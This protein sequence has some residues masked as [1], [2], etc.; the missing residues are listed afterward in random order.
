MICCKWV[1]VKISYFSVFG[2]K[3]FSGK[4]CRSQGPA[5]GTKI[6]VQNVFRFIL[7][8]VIRGFLTEFGILEFQSISS[9][10]NRNCVCADAI[11]QKQNIIEQLC[12]GFACLFVPGSLSLKSH[13]YILKSSSLKQRQST[14]LHNNPFIRDKSRE[15][16][17][18]ARQNPQK[19][20]KR[21]ELRV[22]V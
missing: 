18:R 20:T 2:S 14:E 6:Q 8:S 9:L 16:L 12:S 5:N 22:R 1:W 19:K 17:Q 21:N 4:R 7:M 3:P 10:Y 13:K 11:K 15:Q